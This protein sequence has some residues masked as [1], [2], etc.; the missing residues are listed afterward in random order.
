MMT[1]LA[2]I[3]FAK[4]KQRRA[5]EFR[6]AADEIVR[7]RVQLFA[8]NVAPGLFGVVL[9]VKVDRAGAPVVFLARH[10]VPTFEQK[11]L[12]TG[13][14]EFVGERA[15]ARA[16][17]DNDY[18]VVVVRCH[19]ALRPHQGDGKATNRKTL[20]DSSIAWNRSSKERCQS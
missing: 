9:S 7:M 13:G 19:D 3:F 17:A 20:N 5:V 10:V 11:D 15:A 18:V 14:R 16:R 6:V 2:K 8:V 4:T 12:L 1:N